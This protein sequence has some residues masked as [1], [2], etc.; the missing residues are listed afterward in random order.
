VPVYD[1]PT[2]DTQ[3]QALRLAAAIPSD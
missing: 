1:R 2:I 3:S